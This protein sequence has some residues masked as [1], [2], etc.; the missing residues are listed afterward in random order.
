MAVGREQK[1][2]VVRAVGSQFGGRRDL[3]YA[4]GGRL[5]SSASISLTCFST[6]GAVFSRPAVISAACFAAFARN[7]PI[8]C[9]NVS[10]AW[11]RSF[12]LCEALFVIGLQGEQRF[13]GIRLVFLL[14]RVDQVEPLRHR[15]R[16]VADRLPKRSPSEAISEAMSFRSSAALC[17][18]V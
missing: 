15:F 12:D 8:R 10:T 13:D 17:S 11:R 7:S 9:D 2:D 14:Q 6:C 1:T 4:F 18:R 3:E 16:V 5:P